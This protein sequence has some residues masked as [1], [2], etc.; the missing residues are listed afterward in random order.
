MATT[1]RLRSALGVVGILAIAVALPLACSSSSS[2]GGSPPGPDATT[3][4]NGE[5]VL[6]QFD[7]DAPVDASVCFSGDGGTVPSIPFKLCKVDDDCILIPHQTDCCGTTDLI[8]ISKVE[9]DAFT[10]CEN[11][12][13]KRFP[14]KCGCDAAGPQK[15]ED[16]KI[17][18]DPGLV[19]VHCTDLT[20][21]GGICRTSLTDADAGT[22]GG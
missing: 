4:T 3:D 22:D 14:K 19:V 6:I 5:D 20:S 2:D 12:W 1:V 21:G 18:V 8:G 9:S 13:I 15:T 11:S 10:L 17:V 7:A 16:G